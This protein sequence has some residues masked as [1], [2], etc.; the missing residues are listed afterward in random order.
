[1][2]QQSTP[3]R[4]RAWMAV[5]AALPLLVAC[6]GGGGP[7]G[8]APFGNI[9]G[10]P[11]PGTGAPVTAPVATPAPGFISTPTPAPII[12]YAVT[13][14]V[15]GDTPTAGV[16]YSKPDGGTES[17]DPVDLP[18]TKTFTALEGDFLYISADIPPEG[19]T[20]KVEILVDGRVFRFANAGGAFQGATASELCC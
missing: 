16:L 14:R 17:F 4:P 6:G 20:L 3:C 13:Y 5:A 9:N 10:G 1:M 19:G 12:T 18:W 8:Y 7:A 2:T 15:T 11:A